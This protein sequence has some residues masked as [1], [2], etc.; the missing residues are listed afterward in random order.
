MLVGW[1]LICVPVFS[2]HFS[3]RLPKQDTAMELEPD[4]ATPLLSTTIVFL[5]PRHKSLVKEI[6]IIKFHFDKFINLDI[7]VS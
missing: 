3:G 6:K 2:D 7:T 4:S 5:P 1:S